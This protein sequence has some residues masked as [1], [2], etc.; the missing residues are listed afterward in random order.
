MI[1]LLKWYTARQELDEVSGLEDDVWV[2]GLSGSADGHA[3]L[4]EIQ[5]AYYTLRERE[6]GEGEKRELSTLNS[7]VSLGP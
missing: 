3:A 5:L 6:R 1:Y 7:C 2:P 4:N